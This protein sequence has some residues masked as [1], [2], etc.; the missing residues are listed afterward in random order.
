MIELARL[1]IYEGGSRT[2]FAFQMLEKV[3]LK[4]DRENAATAQFLIGEFYY[5][6]GELIKAAGEFLQ[7]AFIYPEEPDL[8]AAS[9][10]RAAEM[11]SLAG[12]ER[13]V[14]ELVE[15]L[16]K[17]FPDSQWTEEG[18]KLLKRGDG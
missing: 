3:V 11:M 16:D 8:M 5:R 15:R 9:I 13:E 18:R 2:D 12:R 4:E 10:F 1:Y 6:R 14:R 17:N 7:A